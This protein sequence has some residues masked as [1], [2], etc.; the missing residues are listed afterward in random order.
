M[1]SSYHELQSLLKAVE[2]Q[3]KRIAELDAEIDAMHDKINELTIVFKA[4]LK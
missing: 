1:T 2:A 3:E 4:K